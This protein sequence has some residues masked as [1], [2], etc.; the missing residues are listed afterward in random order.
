MTSRPAE[1]VLKYAS[2][3]L[4]AKVM[5]K[6]TP[7]LPLTAP[8]SKCRELRIIISYAIRFCCIVVSGTLAAQSAAAGAVSAADKPTTRDI[9]PEMRPDDRV[10]DGRV[11]PVLIADAGERANGARLTTASP[12]PLLNQ[13]ETIV[14]TIDVYNAVAGQKILIQNSNHGARYFTTDFSAA[15]KAALA[16]VPGVAYTPVTEQQMEITLAAGSYK[17]PIS[18][19]VTLQTIPGS[20]DDAPWAPG[21]QL[22]VDW[23]LSSAPSNGAP[24]ESAY[25]VDSKWISYSQQGTPAGSANQAGSYNGTRPGASSDARWSLLRSIPNIGTGETVTFEIGMTNYALTSATTIQIRIAGAGTASDAD[26]T[27][28]LD[29]A[30]ASARDENVSYDLQ[31]GTL[32]FGPKAVF[33]FLFRMTA[34]PVG[35]NK[36]YILDIRNSQVGTIDVAQAGVRLGTLSLTPIKPLI[37]V[38][39]ASG[40]FGV[41]R[42][43]FK[44]TYPGKDR[45][46]WAAAQGFGIVRVPFLFENIQATSSAPLDEGAMRQLDPVLGE[47]ATQRLICLLDMHNYGS[48]YL[49]TSPTR[50]GIPGTVDVSNARLADLWARIASRYKDN[51][52]VWFDLMNEPN[53]QTALEWVKTDNA[54]AAAIR[55]TGAPNKIIFQGTAWDGAW[56]WSTS[57]NATQMLKAYDPGGNFAF[58]AHQYLDHDGS[59]TSPTCIAGSGAT[60]L[61]PFTTWLK[62]YGM[63]GILGEVSWA[64]NADC[65]TEATALLEHWKAAAT[66]SGG[67]IGLTYWAAGPW[68]PDSYMYLAEPRPFPTGADPAQLKMLKSYLLR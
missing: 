37:G 66:A 57:G 13:G 20:I 24:V 14:N 63:Q 45:I 11:A 12:T 28:G 15:V 46:D 22:Q 7:R 19:T 39:E 47:C 65:I 17:I 26:F 10:L 29:A 25:S 54:I 36:D 64:A 8:T 35:A 34:G 53:Q 31:T 6:R 16:A 49:D 32:T 5:S 33:P 27:Q 42:Y 55:A 62:K 2:E 41:G 21:T 58:E 48:Y 1:T 61:K 30:I 56:T 43:N 3:P 18:Q 60:R 38:N 68:W 51:A 9:V 52:W 4:L 50:Q 44:Y 67:Y 59:G 40:D 23:L